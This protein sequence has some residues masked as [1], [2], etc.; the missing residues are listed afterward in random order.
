[1]FCS[2]E[3]RSRTA[4]APLAGLLAIA[5]AAVRPADVELRA[6]ARFCGRF[7]AV[8]D[9]FLC[10]LQ[11]LGGACLAE[12]VGLALRQDLVH[13]V[14][15]Q[16]QRQGEDREYG[17]QRGLASIHP[18]GKCRPE[19]GARGLPQGIAPLH[20][21]QR[22]GFRPSLPGRRE[23]L[24]EAQP[25]I[26]E[27][28]QDRRARTADQ[29]GKGR[30]G[31]RDGDADAGQQRAPL[32]RRESGDDQ[33]HGDPGERCHQRVHGIARGSSS[34]RGPAEFAND[35]VERVHAFTGGVA[36]LRHGKRRIGEI[37]IAPR[38]RA[39]R[40][41]ASCNVTVACQYCQPLKSPLGMTVP[42]ACVG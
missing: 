4:C 38:M 37:S 30:H 32:K 36:R 10:G 24:L 41:M 21:V 6:L 35:R 22:A 7:R 17:N 16:R 12:A 42:L 19:P 2:C 33:H 26:D 15:K 34:G 39:T 28:H 9:F 14:G 40:Q 3:A 18:H 29:P 8:G 23:P 31:Q 27:P 11:G 25:E 20:V 5:W 1:M 13:R